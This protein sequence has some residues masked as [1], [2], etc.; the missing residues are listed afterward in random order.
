MA[1]AKDAQPKGL[2]PLFLL[3]GLIINADKNIP[4]YAESTK[5]ALEYSNYVC[6]KRNNQKHKHSINLTCNCL[7]SE[8][9]KTEFKL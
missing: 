1:P 4:Y 9:M 5:D 2:F 8:R 7:L 3:T 6:L